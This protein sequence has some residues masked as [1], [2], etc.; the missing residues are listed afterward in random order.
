MCFPSSKN[1]GNSGFF[2]DKRRL[3]IFDNR[4][5]DEYIYIYI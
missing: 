2:G 5:L 1:I 3:S 4:H